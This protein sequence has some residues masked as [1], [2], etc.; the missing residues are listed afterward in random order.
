M[1]LSL[2]QR[3]N[4]KVNNIKQADFINKGGFFKN[5]M[6]SK[7]DRMDEAKDLFQ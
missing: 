3:R 7:E 2:K 6:Q 5:M 1:L 4:L